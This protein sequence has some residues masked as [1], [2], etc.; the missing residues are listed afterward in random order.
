MISPITPHNKCE[1]IVFG[2]DWERHPS[3][4][5]HLI[6]AMAAHFDVYWV[7]SIGLRRPTFSAKDLTRLAEK[8][9]QTC[10]FSGGKQEKNHD[11]TDQKML[12]QMPP[13]ASTNANTTQ[14][15]AVM[16]NN[17]TNATDYRPDK[18]IKPLVWPL[19]ELGWLQALN[20]AS[21]GLHLPP[22]QGLRLVWIALPSAV[23][24]LPALDA[25]V[26]IYYCGD[27]FGG[28]AG[29]DNDKVTELEE[30]LVEQADLIFCASKRLFDRFP[31]H[32]TYL[33]SHG[34]DVALFSAPQPA[35]RAK[36]F[37]YTVGFYGSLNDWL[38]QHLIA[39]LAKARP[40]VEFQFVGRRDCDVSELANCDNITLLPAVPHTQLPSYV[41]HW[42]A[43][44]MPFICN[45]QIWACNPLKLREYLAT[46]CPVISSDFPSA[47]RYP[48]HVSIARNLAEWL[49]AI[50]AFCQLTPQHRSQFRKSA[51]CAVADESWDKR[52]ADV[53]SLINNKLSGEVEEHELRLPTKAS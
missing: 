6:T 27:D 43:A 7:N 46:G 9:R 47:Q 53:I 32:K 35:Q 22:K 24:Y 51:Q 48:S 41:Q 1:L 5:Q 38:D 18:L 2:E 14:P 3:S 40:N 19:A 31:E 50:D 25:D 34:V 42:D 4:S 16:S 49:E 17:A 20:N 26:V 37:Q 52:A 45:K 30:R 29:V 21:L 33:I 39:Q 12:P 15:S 36:R 44:I 13:T 10:R 11:Y 23:D 28:L 8:I